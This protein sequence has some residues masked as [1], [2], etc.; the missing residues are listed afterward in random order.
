MNFLHPILSPTL[1]VVC[2]K[3]YE[4]SGDNNCTMCPLGMYKV[5]RGNEVCSVCPPGKSTAAAGSFDPS[6]CSKYNRCF[7]T[8]N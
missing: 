2:D 3:G 5:G 7:T 8:L 4:S 6:D 1:F